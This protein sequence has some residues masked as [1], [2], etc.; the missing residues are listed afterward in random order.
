LGLAYAKGS[1]LQESG[2]A[3]ERAIQLAPYDAS[4]IGD[5]STTEI[6]LDRAGQPG[7]RDRAIALGEQAVRID[8][9]NPRANLTRAVVMQVTGNLPEATLSVERALALDPQSTNPRLYLTATQVYLSSGRP[10]DA[11]RIAQLGIASVWPPQSSVDLRIES[12]RA[13]VALGRPADA[14]T[15]LDAA[16]AISPNEPTALQL[17]EQ[18]RASLPK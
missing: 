16:L 4:Y 3:F 11:V 17:R 2:A 13:L 6:L 10:A 14:L 1:K 8:P 5:L 15:Q 18:I 12:A 7:A 9:N